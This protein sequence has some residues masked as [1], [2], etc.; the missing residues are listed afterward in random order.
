MSE[1]TVNMKTLKQEVFPV[2][3][4]STATL[5]ELKKLATDTLDLG[6]AST[7]VFKGSPLKNDEATLEEL[8]IKDGD[9]IVTVF[10]KAKPVAVADATPAATASATTAPVVE[11]TPAPAAE[12]VIPQEWSCAMCTYI[13]NPARSVCEMCE[14]PNPN[15]P[16]RTT[17][18]NSTSAVVSPRAAVGSNVD[19][20]GANLDGVDEATLLAIQNALAE[21]MG[22]DDGEG[23]GMRME[24]D[25]DQLLQMAETDP[26][27]RLQVTQSLG[28]P[29]DATIEQMRAGLLQQ[30]LQ[31]GQDDPQAAQALLSYLMHDPAAQEQLSAALGGQGNMDPEQLRQTLMALVQQAGGEM[32]EEDDE[33]I[34]MDDDMGADQW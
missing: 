2:K 7:C 8:N 3:I 4:S 29:D 23:D 30:S 12:V 19:L 18:P 11:A 31:A 27:V 34:E 33:D 9:A 25:V 28:L 1:I 20:S 16:A 14:S 15:R 5:G 32:I 22:D 10:K 21:D 26:N 6:V 13:N 17:P 24:V